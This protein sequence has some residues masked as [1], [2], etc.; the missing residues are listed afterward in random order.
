MMQSTDLA[1]ARE[2]FLSARYLLIKF[3]NPATLQ[4]LAQ[5]GC[6]AIMWAPIMQGQTGRL[7]SWQMQ[8]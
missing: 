2:P 7:Q 6:I 4:Q 5:A 1:Q 3:I 8:H